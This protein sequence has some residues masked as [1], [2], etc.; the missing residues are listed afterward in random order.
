MESSRLTPASTGQDAHAAAA[1]QLSLLWKALFTI[2]NDKEGREV[3]N[4]EQEM[5]V[6]QPTRPRRPWDSLGKNTGVGCHFLLQCMKVKS[7]SENEVAQLC[8][9]LSD[10][11]DCTLTSRGR[12]LL[13]GFLEL[14]RPWGF[15][16]EARRG[17]WRPLQPS[18]GLISRVLNIGRAGMT[19]PWLQSPQCLGTPS[20]SPA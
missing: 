16:H 7:E 17:H 12:G 14:R 9:T 11:M 8:L 19:R 5:H 10:P 18:E 15:S 3:D 13:R 1:A 6:W 2:L 20:P 4:K